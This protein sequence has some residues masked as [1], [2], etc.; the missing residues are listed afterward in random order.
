[1][2]TVESLFLDHAA[3]ELGTLCERI[4]TCI[5]KLTPDQIWMRGAENQ[6]AAGNLLLHLNGNVRQWILSGIGGE[7]DDRERDAEFAA[8]GGLTPA[9]LTARLREMVQDAIGVIRS[10]PHSRLT[11]RL[12]IQGFDVTVLEAIYH[13]TEH[14]SGHTS[15]II[16]ITKMVTGE[17]LGFY[18][19]LS[20]PRGAKGQTP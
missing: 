13:V 15:Q 8:R 7:P 2:P 1:M 9:E 16:F 4:A 10:L 20:K 17:D 5:A 14:F 18:S 19:Y 6:N 12:T 11:E 3:K